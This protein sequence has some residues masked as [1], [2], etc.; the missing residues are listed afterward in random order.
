[1]R[2][3]LLRQAVK[4][5]LSKEALTPRL[6]QLKDCYMTDA[7]S[8]SSPTMARCVRAVVDAQTSKY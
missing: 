3:R 7:I 5:P 6:L 8:R 1:L 2:H 4:Q